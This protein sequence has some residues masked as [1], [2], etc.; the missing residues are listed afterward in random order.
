MRAEVSRR[1]LPLSRAT[2][3]LWRSPHVR[4]THLPETFS[5]ISI[6]PLLFCLVAQLRVLWVEGREEYLKEPLLSAWS[7][8]VLQFSKLRR[9]PP[10]R[11]SRQRRPQPCFLATARSSVAQ[12]PLST[13]L[14]EY[15]CTGTVSLAATESPTV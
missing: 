10:N 5:V 1:P 12:C 13:S 6:S 2:S 9:R 15:Y 8:A 4:S 3:F 7:L 11:R 14:S